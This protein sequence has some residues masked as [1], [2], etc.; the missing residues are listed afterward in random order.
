LKEKNRPSVPTTRRRSLVAP[1]RPYL[2]ILNIP[3][4]WAPSPGID[5][6]CIFVSV[7]RLRD[8][9]LDP[10]GSAHI[11]VDQTLR[12][13]DKLTSHGIYVLFLSSNQVFDGEA[14]SVLPGA[15]ACPVSEYGRQKAITEKAILNRI[16]KGAPLGIL[17]LSKV[18]SPHLEL[19][20]RWIETL[21]A[22]RSI[23]AF[24]DMAIAPVSVNRPAGCNVFRYR[25]S[26]SKRTRRRSGINNP[27]QRAFRRDAPGR[28]TITHHTR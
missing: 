9:A 3:D 21:R 26:H 28:D 11:N 27:R 17:R 15:P 13:I 16:A 1:D 25:P 7:A 18:V 8:C 6:A 23:Q 19:I 12:L 22:G 14:P 5:S 4:N 20:H 2:D 24:S 10:A